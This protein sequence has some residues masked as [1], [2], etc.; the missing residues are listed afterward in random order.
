M[1][2]VVFNRPGGPEVLELAEV[3][4]PKPG[5]G[6]VLIEVGASALNRADLLQRRGLYPPPEGASDILG[7]ECAGVVAGL[8]AGVGTKIGDRVMALLPGGGYA[9]RV[10]VA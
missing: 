2:A 9:E 3:P 5:P 10:I 6:E 1:K 8:G 7:L 4:D